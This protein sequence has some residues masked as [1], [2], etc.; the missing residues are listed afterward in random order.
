MPATRN[1]T[2]ARQL[3]PLSVFAEHAGVSLATVR[4]WARNGTLPVWR[5]APTG[6]KAGALR[7]DLGDLEL[8]IRRERPERVG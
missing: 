2:P 7:A 8:V 1:R 4:R 3:V 5:A 6:R